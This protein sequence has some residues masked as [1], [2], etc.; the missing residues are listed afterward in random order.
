MVRLGKTAYG[1][2]LAFQ[3]EML[4][5][6]QHHMIR[7]TLILT[8]HPAVITLGIRGRR[9]HILLSPEELEQNGVELFEINRGGDV[10]YHGPGQ[11][12]GYPVFHLDFIG[13]NI[14]KFVW[15]IEEVFL[16][17]LDREFGIQA[18]REEGIHT[19]I[20]VNNEKITAIGIAVKR[21]VTMHGFA[22]NV[23]TDLS[24]FNWI[25]PCGIPDRGVTSLEKLMDQPMD[26]FEVNRMVE[27]YFQEVFGGD[28]GND[29]A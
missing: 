15:M 26:F 22:F 23:G 7:D 6:R 18:H 24:H 5:K 11:I 28:H 1:E 12:V 17:L 10:T 19:G 4:E 20:W 27:F 21:W 13:K 16:R 9:E 29:Q 25:F 14:R 3:W 2:A 8:E